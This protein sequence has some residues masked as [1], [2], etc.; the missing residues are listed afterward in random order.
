MRA[1]ATPGT[2]RSLMDMNALVDVRDL[3]PNVRVP[4]LVVHRRS[5]ALFA[6]GEAEY[7][8]DR[9]PDA[10]LE[11]IDGAD[12]FVAGDPAQILDVVEPFLSAT[13]KPVHHRALAAVAAA[14]GRHA[15][16]VIDSLVLAG[17]R[18]RHS[19]DGEVVVLFD[20]PATGVRAGLGALTA[21]TDAQLGLA[22]AEVA[23][24]GGPVSGPGVDV[25][26]R[27]AACAP[28]GQVL[29]S[30]TAGVL[31]SGSGIELDAVGDLGADLTE[32]TGAMRALPGRG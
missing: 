7:V 24:D 16:T 27:L 20:G 6:A 1:S 22:I 31:L 3:L 8:A 23:V 10:K 19:S 4:T 29:V 18:R 2:I 5:D 28:R 14:G 12:H 11:L 32:P 9:I 15:S 30:S 13:P 26:R 25:A 21:E 17:G